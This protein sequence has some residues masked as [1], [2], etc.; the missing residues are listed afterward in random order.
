[1]KNVDVLESFVNGESGAKTKTLFID[2][3]RL[4]NYRTC[5]AERTPRTDGSHSFKVNTTK[6]SNSTTRIQ[7]QLMDLVPIAGLSTVND[8]PEGADSLS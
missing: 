1:M 4:Y 6:Y 3:N 2:G 5:I 8:I 7:N